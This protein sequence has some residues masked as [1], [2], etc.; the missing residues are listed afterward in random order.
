MRYRKAAV[1]GTIA[2]ELRTIPE[3]D[4]C[5]LLLGSAEGMQTVLDS[6]PELAAV[7]PFESAVLVD[8]CNDDELEERLNLQLL[9]GGARATEDA[10]EVALMVLDRS[11]NSPNYGSKSSILKLISQAKLCAYK[12]G[13]ARVGADQSSGPLLLPQDFDSDFR[14]GQKG[15]GSVQPDTRL[16]ET[17]QD[18]PSSAGGRRRP[19]PEPKNFDI[20]F[21]HALLKTASHPKLFADLV[22]CE[23]L[24]RKFEGYS[25]L[26]MTVRDT[27][28]NP[29]DRIP[30]CFVFKGPPGECSSPFPWSSGTF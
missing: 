1:A 10:R 9:R 11:R 8:E 14:P 26:A 18:P 2:T 20:T 3:Y 19:K 17:G 24:V 21:D 13:E 22:G 15:P 5:V 29:Q 25:Y 4:Q 23:A 30:F 12:R 27:D 6:Q 7:F 16:R 28:T